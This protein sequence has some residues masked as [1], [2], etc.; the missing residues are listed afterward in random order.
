MEIF[1]SNVFSF[2]LKYIRICI[3]NYFQKDSKREIIL[4]R[5]FFYKSLNKNFW[6]VINIF[7][8]F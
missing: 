8:Y 3:Q 6:E 5:I 4:D 1:H 2:H 7:I